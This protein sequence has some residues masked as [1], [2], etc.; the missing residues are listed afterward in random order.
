MDLPHRPVDHSPR[1]QR[2][3]DRRNQ[4]ELCGNQGGRLRGRTDRRHDRAR[5]RL[6]QGVRIVG[7][8]HTDEADKLL[9][10]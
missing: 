1:R 8:R 9:A 3:T 2:R 5:G 10:G 7:R 6:V 4:R